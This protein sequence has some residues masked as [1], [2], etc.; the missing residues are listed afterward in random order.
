MRLAIAALTSAL[1]IC[2]ATDGAAQITRLLPPTPPRSII[3]NYVPA[4]TVGADTIRSGETE[5]G[6]MMFF[7]DDV[8]DPDD[9]R[10]MPSSG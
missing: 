4:D 5:E 3:Y 8:V 2:A 7:D 1:S 6:L 9:G 10:S